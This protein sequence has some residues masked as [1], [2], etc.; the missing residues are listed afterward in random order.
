MYKAF[1]GANGWYTAWEDAT[2]THYQPQFGGRMT[3]RAAK[4]E[5]RE[6]NARRDEDDDDEEA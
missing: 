5:A 3:E 2:G 6:L 4:A 1:R